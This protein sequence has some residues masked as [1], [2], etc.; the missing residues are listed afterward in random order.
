M[1]VVYLAEQREPIRREV[2]LKVIKPEMSGLDHCELH[3][4]SEAVK[5]SFGLPYHT[6]LILSELIMYSLDM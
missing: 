4:S 5:S 1:G 2:A 3:P 6:C